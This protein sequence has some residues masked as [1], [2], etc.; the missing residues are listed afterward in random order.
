M[1]TRERE[2]NA[3]EKLRNYLPDT[4]CLLI[5]NSEETEI[6]YHGIKIEVIPVWKWLLK[7]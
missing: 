4:K 2:L 3:L 1:N 7:K 5:T 6:D